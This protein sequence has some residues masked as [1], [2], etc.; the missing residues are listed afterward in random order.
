[1]SHPRAKKAAA[2]SPRRPARP[3]PSSKASPK[4]AAAARRN[5]KLGGRPPAELP[6]HLAELLADPPIGDP[7]K[8]NGW[9]ADVLL[10]LSQARIEG[11]PGVDT[12]ARELRANFSVM[13]K[14]ADHDLL[15]R[16]QL[17]LKDEADDRGADDG[18]EEEELD[19]DAAGTPRALRS[20]P[21]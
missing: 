2:K 3:R 1:M 21:S 7:L 19:G 13:A 20:D 4:K 5:G 15:Y 12:L 18:P 16:A 6:E 17:A 8:R 14:M 10:A 9:A 11:S